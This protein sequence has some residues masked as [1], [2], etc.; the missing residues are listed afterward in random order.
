MFK[1]YILPILEFATPIYNPYYAKDINA[2]EKIQRDFVRLVYKRMPNYQKNPLNIPQYTELLTAFGL[3]L[4]EIRRLKICLTMFHSYM[5][6]H[7]PLGPSKA[8]LIMSS[9]TRG[10]SQ[11]IITRPCTKDVR[12]YSFFPRMSTIYSQLPK[13]MRN[14]SCLNF[15]KQLES[16]DLNPYLI[17]KKYE[18]FHRL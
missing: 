12:H 13:N 4:L 15:S 6:G 14:S 11:K 5:N 1:S 2:L 3:E 9:K 7:T 16:F 18:P 8:F 17:V 10:D